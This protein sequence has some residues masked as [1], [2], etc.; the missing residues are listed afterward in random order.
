MANE[1]LEF[2]RLARKRGAIA[3]V[4]HVIFNLA[5]VALTVALVIIFPDT[6]LP[7]LALLLLSKWRTIA[8]RP[9]YW[10][11]NL[12]SSLPD[13]TFGAAMVTLM[14]L[15][16]QNALISGGWAWIPQAILGVFYTVWLIWMKP[17]DSKKWV[18]WQAGISQFFSVSA[19]FSIAG[20]LPL[21]VV[22]LLMF[23]TAFGVARQIFTQYVEV[24]RTLLALAYG[25]VVAIIAFA[26]WH[27][28]VGYAVGTMVEVPQAAII[29][30]A[31]GFVFAK[32]YDAHETGSIKW[33]TVGWPLV[34][35]GAILLLVVIVGGAMFV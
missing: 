28:T 9:R 8:V 2:I 24:S 1:M 12:V 22:M 21:V 29:I 13:L 3:D 4:F 30:S 35:V 15:A 34:A 33:A 31:L 11:M 14:W 6:P 25:F 17:Q 20:R 7:A 27:W 18:F 19:I 32:I 16:G 10:W 26:A 23:I 5:F